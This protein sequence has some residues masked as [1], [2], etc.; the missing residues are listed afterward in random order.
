MKDGLYNIRKSRENFLKTT[1]CVHYNHSRVAI[2]FSVT[3]LVFENTNKEREMVRSDCKQA[4][5]IFDSI[6]FRR[7]E[8]ESPSHSSL[9]CSLSESIQIMLLLKSQLSV[10]SLKETLFHPPKTPSHRNSFQSKIFENTNTNPS[11]QSAV[12]RLSV[13]SSPSYLASSKSQSHSRTR[14]HRNFDFYRVSFTK[15]VFAFSHRID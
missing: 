4:S 7:K 3:N 12:Y 11:F 14:S 8:G 6:H 2:Y 5:G 13:P 9:V 1:I 10:P 15:L